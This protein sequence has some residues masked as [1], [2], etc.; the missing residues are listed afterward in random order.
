MSP[1]T[2]DDSTTTARQGCDNGTMTAWQ[3]YYKYTTHVL[4][5][6][7]SHGYFMC[8]C[9]DGYNFH[10]GLNLDTLLIPRVM[11]VYTAY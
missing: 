11:R 1:C 7:F 3:K 8:T 2:C 4:K 10:P 9:C 6:L 5:I